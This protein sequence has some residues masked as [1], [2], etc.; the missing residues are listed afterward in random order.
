M[1]ESLQILRVPDNGW[2]TAGN[3]NKT[4]TP[5][6]GDAKA[7]W[8]SIIPSVGFGLLTMFVVMPLIKKKIIAEEEALD[9]FAFSAPVSDKPLCMDLM[10][11]HLLNHCAVSSAGLLRPRQ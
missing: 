9:R 3:K 8:I 2:W 5:S 6:V 1:R 7:V 11:A 4:W 10:E